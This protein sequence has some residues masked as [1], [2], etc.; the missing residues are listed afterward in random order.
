MDSE[1]EIILGQGYRCVGNLKK[2]SWTDEE[3]FQG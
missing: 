3:K 2:E 1:M